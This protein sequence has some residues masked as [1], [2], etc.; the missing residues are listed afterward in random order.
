MSRIK[1]GFFD[2]YCRSFQIYS[3]QDCNHYFLVETFQKSRS[4]SEITHIY[5]ARKKTV[6]YITT[7]TEFFKLDVD[8]FSF[9]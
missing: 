3:C 9:E 4:S 2:H 7:I 8:T 1:L 5:F 6:H